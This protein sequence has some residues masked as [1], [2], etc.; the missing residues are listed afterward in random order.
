MINDARRCFCLS[1]A[2]AVHSALGLATTAH[3]RFMTYYTHRAKGFGLDHFRRLGD[4]VVYTRMLSTATTFAR[5][6][7][8]DTCSAV[9]DATAVDKRHRSF[10]SCSISSFQPRICMTIPIFSCVSGTAVLNSLRFPSH[11]SNLRF[12]LRF[13][14]AWRFRALISRIV[15]STASG[16]IY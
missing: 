9:S 13:A 4:F 5:Q 3:R 14:F 11:F 12:A 8:A 10:R 2:W 6:R 15:N 16:Y 1:F 7:L